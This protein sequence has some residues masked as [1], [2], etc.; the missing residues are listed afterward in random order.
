MAVNARLDASVANADGLVRAGLLPEWHTPRDR[1]L[2]TYRLRAGRVRLARD[3][4]DLYKST[5]H[6]AVGAVATS[7]DH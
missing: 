7:A 5:D 2:H 3:G 1:Y 4:R 6:W